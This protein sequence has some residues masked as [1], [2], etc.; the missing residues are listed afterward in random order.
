MFGDVGQG[1][2][3]FLIGFI[4]E[5][6]WPV[7]RLLAICGASS[8]VFGFVFGSVFGMENII[9][10]LWTHPIDEPLKVLFIPLIGGIIILLLGLVLAGFEAYWSG[11]LTDWLLVEAAVIVMYVSILAST[12]LPGA[13]MI[14]I[15]G[16]IWY[17]AG[18]LYRDSN[19]LLA[20]IGRALGAL[21]ESLMQLLIN[22][23]SFFRVGAFALAHAGL[24]L[25]F[26]V[27]ADA[28]GS[29]F[30]AVPILILGNIIIIVLEGLVVS[31][32]TTRLVLFEFFIRFLHGSGRI[33]RPLQP[34][35][36]EKPSSRSS[37]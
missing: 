14:T 17:F 10:P 4:L 18:N 9:N 34:P 19:R 8:I 16:V 29:H 27:L 12:V 24:S 35:A 22:T 1:L 7:L 37:T 5:R 32:Q 15:A 26:I 21:V 36:T 2:I 28:S 3:L 11:H 13:L 33:F 23:L 6:R 25:A 30:A 31:I 20:T